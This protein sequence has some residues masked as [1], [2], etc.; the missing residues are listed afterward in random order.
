MQVLL[1]STL[2]NADLIILGK[3]TYGFAESLTGQEHASHKCG[4]DCAAAY[5]QD[6]QFALGRFNG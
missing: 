4:G 1:L 5:H 6:S 3:R 2:A